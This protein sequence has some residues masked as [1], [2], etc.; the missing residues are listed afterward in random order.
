MANYKHLLASMFPRSFS[1]EIKY[2]YQ[3]FYR[4]A[5]LKSRIEIKNSYEV[6]KK[7]GTHTYFGYYDISPFNVNG[8][9]F[10]YLR[11]EGENQSAWVILSLL[12][13]KKERVVAHTNAWNWQQGAR[14]RWMPNNSRKICFNDYLDNKYLAR[15]INIDDGQESRIDAPLYDVSPDGS[16]G[17]SIDFERL[18]VK[19]PGYGYYCYPYFENEES[20]SE[21]G[22]DLVNLIDN[23]KR[24]IITYKSIAELPGCETSDYRVNYINHLSFSPSGEKFLFFWLYACKG[25]HIAHLIVYDLK[26]EQF[27]V[28]ETAERVSHYVWENDDN[29][30]CTAF[31]GANECHY[32]RYTVSTKGKELLCENI[33]K[34]DGHPSMYA[35]NVIITDTYPDKYGYQRIFMVDLKNSTRKELVSVYSDSRVEGEKRTDM[36]PRLNPDK[37]IISFDANLSGRRSL[38]MLHL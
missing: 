9:E 19:R 3:F 26:K 2:V 37:T 24:R 17:L 4:L 1:L 32:Y 5:K 25:P 18:Q 7:K 20:L 12:D 30:I 23:A 34:R 36:H 28:L 10:V 38:F 35:D 27:T 14:L 31:K 15:I 21:E 8:K 29:I 16:W 22:I 33:L 11:L 6:I 13:G